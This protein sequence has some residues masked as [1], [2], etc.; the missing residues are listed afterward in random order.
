MEALGYS[1][2]NLQNV[3]FFL[4]PGLVTVLLFY[5]QVPDRRKT[6]L[7]I[8]VL[9]VIASVSLTFVTAAIF[10]LINNFA[11]T[12]IEATNPW[13]EGTKIVLGIFIAIILARLV[14]S[15]FFTWLNKK[16]FKVSAYP[17]GRIWN[18]FFRVESKTV[19]KVLLTDGSA[20]IG[21]LAVSSFD[22]NDDVQELILKEPYS[23]DSEKATITKIEETESVLILGTAIMSIEKITQEEAKKLY[24]LPAPRKK[25]K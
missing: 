1:V 3:I 13:F 17:F 11:K 8:V 9:S 5:Y 6:D 12:Q 24:N 16:I 20:Y 25:R 7:T 19:V 15:T 23:F 18:T 2:A 22:P 10:S 21:L 14:E 4:L